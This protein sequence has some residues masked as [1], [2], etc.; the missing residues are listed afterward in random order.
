MIEN[1][2]L[3]PEQRSLLEK[4]MLEI[5]KKLVGANKNAWPPQKLLHRVFA[6]IENVDIDEKTEEI[7]FRKQDEQSSI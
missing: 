2:R 6:Y 3:K 7:I 1:F 4:K 5:N